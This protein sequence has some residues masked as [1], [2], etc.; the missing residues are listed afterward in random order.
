M[1]L[2]KYRCWNTKER[3]WINDFVISPDGK[4]GEC[5]GFSGDIC[6]F[7]F[8]PLEDCILDQF[9]GLHDSQ[10]NPIY[11][12]DILR[13]G[14]FLFEVVYHKDSFKITELYSRKKQFDQ[15]DFNIEF[16]SLGEVSKYSIVASNIHENPE[17]LETKS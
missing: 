4:P 12:G 15:E 16:F 6:S 2:I 3:K 11:E 9:T 1:R 7:S 8:E 10:E 14:Q 13:V 17:L 5:G